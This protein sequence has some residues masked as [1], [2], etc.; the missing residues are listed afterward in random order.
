MRSIYAIVSPSSLI[1]CKSFNHEHQCDFPVLLVAVAIARPDRPVHDGYGYSAPD[2]KLSYGHEKYEKGMPFDFNYDVK[3]H[4]KGLDYGHNS[5]SDGNLVTGK[6]YVLLPDGRT[7]IVTYTADHYKGYQAEVAYEG[8]AKYPEP[9]HYKAAPPTVILPPLMGRQLHPTVILLPLL[10]GR[11]LH[12]TVI[13]PPTYGDASSSYSPILPLFM[14]T[15]PLP[16][17]L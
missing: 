7:Q 13:L 16:T 3:D 9:G 8:E 2:H 10:M 1:I 15:S 4:Y 5:N 12:P 17:E 14:D 11:Q 6:Y